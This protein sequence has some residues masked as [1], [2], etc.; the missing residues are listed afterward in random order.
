MKKNTDDKVKNTRCAIYTRKST[1]EGLDKEFT[2]LDA[3]RESCENYIR[4]QKSQ[5]L[6]ILPDQYNDGGFTGANMERPALMKLLD[7]IKDRKIDCVVVYKVD[8][9]SRSL[10]DFVRLL[11]L[12]DKYEVTFISVTQHFDTNT[13]MGRL[14]LN[15]LLSFAQFEREMI[16]ERTRDKMSAA[17]KKGRW[18]GGKIPLGYDL[19]TETKRL[20][21]N[22]TEAKLVRE[23]FDLYLKEK[24]LRAVTTTLNKR[25][26]KTK[27]YYSKKGKL[28]GGY[29]FQLPV[30]QFILKNRLYTGKIDFKGEIYQG[31]H[32]PIISETI[33]KQ[34][35]EL[36][37]HNKVFSTRNHKNGHVDLLQKLTRCK[38][39]NSAMI[40]TYAIKGNRKYRYYVCVSA[41]K[42][43]YLTCP[44]PSVKAQTLEDAVMDSLRK[45]AKDPDIKAIEEQNRL[46]TENLEQLTGQEIELK[47]KVTELN[48]SIKSFLKNPS[49]QSDDGEK[50]LPRLRATLEDN[51]RSL[52]E[53][54]TGIAQLEERLF[55]FKDVKEA[56]IINTPEWDVL[57][58]IEK[59]RI[60]S[61]ILKS[62]DYDA[63]TNMLGLT[64][65]EKGIR[66]LSKE[67][68]DARSTSKQ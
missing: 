7:D 44:T 48:T 26:I 17:R 16:S 36:S 38:P 58:P 57:F 43:G 40:G 50:T 12:F 42:K 22:E 8:R 15:I 59:R 13:S 10:M 63:V 51:E 41:Q 5:G 65:N 27:S 9:L 28:I 2:T 31:L 24:S 46:V 6:S 45:I 32:E 21:I 64:L 1:N 33:Y 66:L 35:K 34:A 20:I 62:V 61:V 53:I 56:M 49:G 68:Q 37:A 47:E 25:G 14:T 3:Q 4:S 30:V 18:I 55:N 19:D 39:C 60:L 23:I 11:G 67:I 29:E 54:R 52:S